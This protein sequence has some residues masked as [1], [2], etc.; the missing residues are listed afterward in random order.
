MEKIAKKIIKSS[1]FQ[2]KILQC[3]EKR[4]F[5]TTLLFLN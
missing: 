5:I 3:E 4:V 2:V 1:Y